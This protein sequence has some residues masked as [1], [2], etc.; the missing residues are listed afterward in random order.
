M[1]VQY[2]NPRTPEAEASSS[3]LLWGQFGLHNKFLDSQG[4]TE[5]PC[6]EEPSKQTKIKTAQS[7]TIKESGTRPEMY[8]YQWCIELWS[9]LRKWRN[10]KPES[11][12]N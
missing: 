7:Y 2:F 9:P 5:K 8:L 6:L 1:V 3:L 4:N 10:A 12:Q 11:D